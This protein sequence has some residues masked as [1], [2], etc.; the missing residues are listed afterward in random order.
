MFTL[1]PVEAPPVKRRKPRL[2]EADVV[3]IR[4]LAASGW[5]ARS[6]ADEL[7]KPLVTVYDA[8]VG[9]TY[10]GVLPPPVR[11]QRSAVSEMQVAEMRSLYNSGVSFTTIMGRFGTDRRTTRRLLFGDAQSRN[12]PIGGVAPCVPRRTSKRR[13]I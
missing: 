10:R 1:T 5:T 11:F 13:I 4:E 7:G 8:A 9:N 12:T 6:I 2:R 3:R